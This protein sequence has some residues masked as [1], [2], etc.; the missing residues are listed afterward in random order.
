[1]MVWLGEGGNNRVELLSLKILLLFVEEKG[2]RSL[3]V[4]GD[5]LNV[6]NWVKRIQACKDLILQNI[7]LYIWYI[8]ESFDSISCSHVYKENNSQMD[9]ASKEGLRLDA[10]VWKIKERLDDVVSRFYHRPFIEGAVV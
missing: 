4:Y 8:I 2:C 10:V 7:L 6:I 1:M 3:K 5:S 9:L